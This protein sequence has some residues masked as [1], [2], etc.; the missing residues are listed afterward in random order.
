MKFYY[1]YIRVHP[2]MFFFSGFKIVT[3]GLFNFPKMSGILA[4]VDSHTSFLVVITYVI[5]RSSC[6]PCFNF[7]TYFHIHFWWI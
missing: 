4:L 5:V 7:G 6:R 2:D 1:C 3:E